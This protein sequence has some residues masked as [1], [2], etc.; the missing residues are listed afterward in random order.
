MGFAQNLKYLMDSHEYS[1]YKM[2]QVLGCSQSTVANLLNGSTDPQRRTK[3]AIAL[4]FGISEKDLCGEEL[5]ELFTELSKEKKEPPRPEA[6]AVDPLDREI[7]E[8]VSRLSV[9]G[10]VKV[11]EQVIELELKGER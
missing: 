8:R 7:L 4:H 10:K 5:P 6:E 1:K 9:E 2:A 11:L 3:A